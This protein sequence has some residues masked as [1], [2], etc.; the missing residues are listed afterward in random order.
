MAAASVSALSLFPAACST[1]VLCYHPPRAFFL[2]Y[3]SSANLTAVRPVV[4]AS[5][6]CC[7]CLL[8]AASAAPLLSHS[9]SLLLLFLA[10]LASRVRACLLA[11]GFYSPLLLSAT[12]NIATTSNLPHPPPSLTPNAVAIASP[13]FVASRVCLSSPPTFYHRGSL[14]WSV[15][16]SEQGDRKGSERNS[17]THTL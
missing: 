1:A 7:C 13:T 2:R 3:H 12:T 17:R 8:L 10:P 4:A 5:A 14:A 6:A 15:I 11:G 9:H 16:P